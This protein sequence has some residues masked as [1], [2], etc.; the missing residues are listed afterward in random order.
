MLL[1]FHLLPQ[2]SRP[3][4]TMH[5]AVDLTLLACDSRVDDIVVHVVART[6]GTVVSLGRLLLCSP[7]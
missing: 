5:F 2:S 7:V 4:A 6:C 1:V 3:R